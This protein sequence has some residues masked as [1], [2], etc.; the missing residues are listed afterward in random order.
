MKKFIFFPL[1]FV[2]LV[3][4]LWGAAKFRIG[5]LPL[6]DG[7]YN[8]TQTVVTGRQPVF[9]WAIG[10]LVSSFT[11]TVADNFPP[12]TTFWDYTGSTTSLNTINFTTRVPYNA[13]SSAL[14]LAANTT[15]AWRVVIY[16]V[17]ANGNSSSATAVSQF[18]TVATAVTLTGGSFDL[19]VD[20]NNPF[21][22]ATQYTVFRFVA[23]DRDRSVK[24]QVFTLSGALVR[25]WPEQTVLKDA[26][27]TQMWDGKNNDG[28]T[29]ARG[30]YL[31]N[32]KDTGEGKG[33][34]RRV[35]VI[36]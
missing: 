35:A 27:Y 9:S 21:N 36:K 23:K 11:V 10:D 14:P 24:L 17:D 28:D 16:N 8:S 4:P 15:Y 7:V 33:V 31:V 19:A 12:T 34:T 18:S 2:F 22:P 1:L 25:D 20:W 26:W 5:T 30:I 6:V 13:D 29:V 3:S 32:L